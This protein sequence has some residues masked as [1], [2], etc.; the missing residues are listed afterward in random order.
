MT[1]QKYID[2]IKASLDR[3]ANSFHIIDI[4]LYLDLRIQQQGFVK[5]TVYF[6]NNTRLHF[7]EFVDASEG[8]LRKLR[9]SYHFQN[10]DYSLIFRYDNSDH[11]PRLPFKDH[12][13]LPGEIV[14]AKSPTLSEV[15]LEILAH[16]SEK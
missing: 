11:K 1:I 4:E 9:Y 3:Y 7:K 13:H 10:A 12:K 2:E 14:S 5:G 16:I 6:V 8:I 15:I